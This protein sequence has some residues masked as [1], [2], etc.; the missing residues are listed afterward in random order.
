MQKI[1][2]HKLS[3]LFWLIAIFD[4]SSILLEWLWP[5]YI[6]KALLMPMLMLLWR[7]SGN[8]PGKYLILIGLLFSWAGDVLLMMEGRHKLFFIFGLAAFLT[9]HILYILFFLKKRTGRSALLRQPW[10]LMLVPAYG[11]ALVW[12]L[13]PKLNDL[14]IPVLAYAMV[15]CTML[16]CSIHVFG[17]VKPKAGWLYCL[18]ALFFVISDSILALDKFYQHFTYAGPII[19]ITYC[20][21]QFLIVR[22]YLKEEVV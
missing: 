22:G 5:H 18:G 20:L 14:K 9:T 3:F 4:I 19:M 11:I 1:A 17:K 21:A 2:Q 6:F 13:Y 7:T 15:I 12:L 16:L 10:W 8:L